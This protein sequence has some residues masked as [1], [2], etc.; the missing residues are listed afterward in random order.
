MP[1][2]LCPDNLKA[3]VL[4]AARFRD[5]RSLQ[6][7]DFRFNK[8]DGTQIYKLAAGHL[9]E[10]K[11]DLLFIGPPG[12]GKSHLAQVLGYE[13]IKRGKTVLYRSVFD[14]VTELLA[15]E[16]GE[17]RQDAQAIPQ[18]RP[19]YHRRYGYQATLA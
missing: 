18:M 13:L 10:E 11:H 4:K 5:Q 19:A 3:A 17:L 14:V 9:L 6:S 16:T 12:V 1:R 8:I 15:L 2:R 7:F